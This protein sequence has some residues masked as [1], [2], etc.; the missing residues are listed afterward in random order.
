MRIPIG[1]IWLVGALLTWAYFMYTRNAEAPE[2]LRLRTRVLLASME[3]TFALIWP[4]FW[5]GFGIGKLL[6]RER[7]ELERRE[8]L[9]Q[10]YDWD[11]EDRGGR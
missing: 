4:L 2:D 6:E 10:L 5:A 11:E 1:E 3:I 8:Q 7:K 9:E